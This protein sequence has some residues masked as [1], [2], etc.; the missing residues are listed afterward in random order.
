MQMVKREGVVI[1]VIPET[2]DGDISIA[3]LERMISGGERKPA[4][5]AITHVPTSSGAT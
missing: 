5:I 1:D 4:L 2:E 3:D